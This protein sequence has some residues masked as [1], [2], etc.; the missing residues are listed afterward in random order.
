LAVGPTPDVVGFVV[1]ERE[2]PSDALI[3]GPEEASAAG[4]VY[5]HDT[6]PGI[7][8]RRAGKGFCYLDADGSPLDPRRRC[9]GPGG[10]ANSLPLI[11]AKAGTQD[12]SDQVVQQQSNAAPQRPLAAI[13]ASLVLGPGLRRDERIERRFPA[14]A[15][16]GYARI[17]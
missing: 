11:P 13:T 6:D 10:L 12:R 15:A 4:L 2:M 16:I 9:P 8:R 3:E 1:R 7:R 17:R 14:G 5:V